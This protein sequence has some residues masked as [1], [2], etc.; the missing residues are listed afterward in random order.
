MAD[1]VTELQ[2]AFPPQAQPAASGSGASTGTEV[3]LGSA[4]GNFY[5]KERA[6]LEQVGKGVAG[7]QEGAKLEG[8]DKLNRALINEEQAGA[9]DTQQSQDVKDLQTLSSMHDA[10]MQKLIA[11]DKPIIDAADKFQFHQYW[12]DQSTGNKILAAISSGLLGFGTGQYH[13]VAM[14]LA[15]KDHQRQV[16][17]LN[18]LMERAKMAGAREDRLRE[19]H[20][21][22]L[23]SMSLMQVAKLKAIASQYA[24]MGAQ[25]A[26]VEAKTAA[27]MGQS[28]AMKGAGEWMLNYLK[29][30]RTKAAHTV[31]QHISQP[32]GNRPGD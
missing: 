31:S 29:G 2:T 28:L 21:E 24:K 4:K 3:P 17:E 27:Q 15:D 18:S 19:V 20:K 23:S 8:E 32:R 30:L 11:K 10:E 13:N 1:T 25:A 6:P 7:I 26:T 22:A 14:E 12:S 9:E 5:G 16:T